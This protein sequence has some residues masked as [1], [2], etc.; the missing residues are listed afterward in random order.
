LGRR[1]Q[2]VSPALQSSWDSPVAAEPDLLHQSMP[3]VVLLCMMHSYSGCQPN[4][5]RILEGMPK[6]PLAT[7]HEK[8]PAA[9]LRQRS[10]V[11]CHVMPFACVTCFA[12]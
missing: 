2:G 6:S 12:A 5:Y 3:R 11:L 9:A 7:V 10:T 1:E 4:R 8:C